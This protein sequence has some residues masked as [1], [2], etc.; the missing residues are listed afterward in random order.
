MKIYWII[1]KINGK[2]YIGQTVKTLEHRWRGHCWECNTKLHGM[3]ISKAISK[4]GKEAFEMELLQ[5][6][7]SIEELNKA[8]Q[9]WIKLL[10]NLAPRG[11]NLKEGGKNGRLSE[12]TKIKI[13]NSNRGKKVSPETIKKLS[14]SHI[15]NK[16]TEETKNKLRAFFIGKPQKLEHIEK[17]S[18]ALEKIIAK[19]YWLKNPEGKII[20][21][22]N[23]AKFC[24]ENKFSISKMNELANGKRMLYRGWTK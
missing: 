16:Q 22:Y 23:L 24:R 10:N 18:K 15:G 12:E 21:I 5:E 1:N 19:T 6:C 3:I 14:V 2:K 17:R 11:Y 8:E 9:K 7:S 13:G 4:Y 20:E